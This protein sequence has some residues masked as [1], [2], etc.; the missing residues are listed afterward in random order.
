[1]NQTHGTTR[2]QSEQTDAPATGSGKWSSTT[3]VQELALFLRSIRTAV[4]VTHAKPDGDAMGS[5]LAIARTLRA[6]RVQAS[7]VLV[8]PVPRWCQDLCDDP[9]RPIPVHELAPG[10]PCTSKDR[11]PWD[12]PTPDTVVVV[13]TGS[14]GQLAEIRPWLEPLAPR[15]CLI[16]HHLHGDPAVAPRRLINTRAA[17]CTEVLAPLCAA[18]LGV[19]SPSR[20][21]S[22]VAEPLYMGLATDTGWFRYSSVTPDT[23]RLAADLIEAGTDHTRLYRLIEQQD[24]APRWRLLGRAL[25]SLELHDHA[26]LA[27]MTLTRKDFA[28]TGAD[29]NDTAGFADM[30]LTVATVELAAVLT[31][32]D[33]PAAAPPVTKFS[34]RSKPGPSAIDVNA[35][36]G[37]LG[38]G[39][40][41]RAAGAR[42]EAP[43]LEA[44]AR[45]LEALSAS[46][47]RG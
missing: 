33:T 28:D 5:A 44:K 6:V 10:T 18:I 41:A 40:H 23:L 2:P 46:E 26:R 39:G 38:G 27:L 31:E 8:G 19:Q 9:A 24:A 35:L 15:A 13:D 11:S 32:Q 12:G 20:L 1:M 34:F 43:L 37:H 7:L 45:L 25:E 36:A 3:T 47:S 29:R 17:S 30:L 14:W 22:E 4:I 42:L 21:P 16:D